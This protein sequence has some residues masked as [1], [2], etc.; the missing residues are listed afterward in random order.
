MIK[1]FEYLRA[2]EH[3]PFQW[4]RHDCCLFAAD[5]VMVLTGN[6]P[7]HDLRG[8]YGNKD[9]ADAVLAVHGGLAALCDAR[10]GPRVPVKLAQRGCIV[11]FDTPDGEALGV[12]DG[13]HIVGAGE[14]GTV[15]YRAAR[16]QI[17]WRVA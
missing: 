16:A 14:L 2:A 6:D 12:L 1:L 15:R 13:P 5:V 7:A 17:A 10:F 4:G 11:L 3:T 8:T 9:E